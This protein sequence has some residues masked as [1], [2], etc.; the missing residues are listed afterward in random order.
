MVKP[1]NLVTQVV[2]S[3]PQRPP[4]PPREADNSELRSSFLGR[5]FFKQPGTQTPPTNSPCSSVESVTNITDKSQKKVEWSSSTE[6]KE[7]PTPSARHDTQSARNL[8]PLP[9]SG[10]RPAKSILKHYNGVNAVDKSQGIAKLSPPHTYLNFATMLESVVKQLAASDRN[11]RIDAYITLNGVLK[12]CGNIPDTHALKAKMGLLAQFIQRDMSAKTESGTTDTAVINHALTLLASLLWKPDVADS[13]DSDFCTALV[14]HAIAAF[15]ALSHSKEVVRLLLFI[16]GQQNFSTRIMT[17]ERAGLLVMALQNIE[18][19][20]KGRS[21]V[22]GRISVYRKLLKQAKQALL[23]NTDWVKHLFADLVSGIIDIRLAAV[24]FGI[25]AALSIGT[26]KQASRAVV[27]LFDMEYTGD[28]RYISYYAKRLS[29]MI[30]KKQDGIFVPQIWSV[31]VLFLRCRPHQLEQWVHLKPW[32]H[33]IQECFNYSDNDVKKQANFAWN[34]LVFTVRPDENTTP[35]MIKMLCQPLSGQLKRKTAGK[36]AREVR[37]ATLASLH[38]LLYYALRPNATPTQL[39]V[40]W[41][42]Y[43][44]QLVGNMMVLRSPADTQIVREDLTPACL[45]LQAL[46]DTCRPRPWVENRVNEDCSISA[47]DLPGLNPRWIR[48][49]AQRVFLVLSP[50]VEKCFWDLADVESPMFAVWK[51]F[52]SSVASAGAKEVI[53]SND[54]MTIMAYFFNLLYELWHKSSGPLKTRCEGGSALFLAAFTK[55]VTT[56]AAHLGVLPFTEK[57]LAISQ[58]DTFAVVATPSHRPARVLGDVKSPLHH[59]IVLIARP[60]SEFICDKDYGSMCNEILHPFFEARK[61]K[62]SRVELA[63]E[64][65]QLLVSAPSTRAGVAVWQVIARFATEATFNEDK[66]SSSGSGSHDR[67]LGVEYRNAVKILEVGL[68]LSPRTLLQEWR[69][70]LEA[71]SMQAGLEVGDGG[72]AISLIEPLSQ[73]LRSLSRRTHESTSFSY[74]LPLLDGATYPRERQSLDAARRRLWGTVSAN[75]KMSSSDP[76][77]HLYEYLSWCL[78]SSYES[79]NSDMLTQ[80]AEVLSA[81]A[82]LLQRCP[83]QHV[84][85]VLV[86]LEVGISHWVLDEA[87]KL[88]SRL[89]N[90]VFTSVFN[91]WTA[92]CSSITRLPQASSDVLHT[93]ETLLCS[94]LESKHRPIVNAT[95][96]FWNN[97]FGSQAELQYPQHVQTALRKLRHAADLQLPSFPENFEDEGLSSGPKFFDDSHQ[98]G[99]FSWSFANSPAGRNYTRFLDP[100]PFPKIPNSI[101][102]ER[103]KDSTPER[104]K[105]KAP[106]RSLTPKLRHDDSQIRFAAIESSPLGD[107]VFDSQLLTDRQREIRERQQEEAALFPDIQPI[108]RINRKTILPTLT[109]NSDLPREDPGTPDMLHDRNGFDNFITSSPTPHRALENVQIEVGTPDPPSSPPE[110]LLE[111]N[112]ISA[113][114]STGEREEDG[115]ALSRN[116][117]DGASFSRLSG[118]RLGKLLIA[119]P[120]APMQSVDVEEMT[121]Y[122]HIPAAPVEAHL[123]G[124]SSNSAVA[125]PSTPIETLGLMPDNQ[126]TPKTPADIFV[127]ALSSPAP[128]TPYQPVAG[129]AY[130]DGPMLPGG[131]SLHLWNK[132]MQR[133]KSSSQLSE[134]DEDSILR[135]MSKL[136]QPPSAQAAMQL[137]PFERKTTEAVGLLPDQVHE[138]NHA[139]SLDASGISTS[140]ANTPKE[141]VQKE[142]ASSNRAVQADVATERTAATYSSF[143]L[144]ESLDHSAPASP[145]PQAPINEPSI[146][147]SNKRRRSVGAPDVRNSSATKK[148]KIAQQSSAPH[149]PAAA[150]RRPGRPRKNLEPRLLEDAGSFEHD[151]GEVSVSNAEEYS[152]QNV[153]AD[154]AEV[155]VVDA[156]FSGAAVIS[157]LK[158]LLVG[159]KGAALARDEAQVVDTLIWDVKRE[160]CE[161]ER[162]GRG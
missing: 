3:L 108:P 105:R 63:R 98:N 32:L 127:D 101:S 147:A 142:S 114:G 133:P 89:M 13:F 144:S 46:F 56:M 5:L 76:Y 8:R 19:R 16:L 64:L 112:F 60:T 77:V 154:G 44:V 140:V 12:A 21:I 118:E 92:V 110:R 39:D 52:A 153:L 61:S 111:E 58:R 57:L 79:L 158:D 84:L 66:G 138:D 41:D 73:T 131:M 146:I 141:I 71:V 145:I 143:R 62:W 36:H 81:V 129:D 117:C 53:V 11:S 47:Q 95:A 78:Q 115:D 34:R 69:D 161:A 4:T 31:V 42:E 96:T 155:A 99:S 65:S 49:N 59:L 157:R 15:Q 67:P 6:Y 107:T 70:L 109:L 33:V 128:A 120:S 116:L 7:P 156:P 130:Q 28:I 100:S 14:D 24:G 106:K 22:L 29:S 20:F 160:V 83:S 119:E 1:G 93:I 134:M 159:L 97:T 50:L 17:M 9:P 35:S 75:Q 150:K 10:G 85:N 132:E 126:Q 45:I 30:R 113:P 38:N 2:G 121:D 40:Y 23:V 68:D 48:K 94:G 91:L 149:Q 104:L 122:Q 152:A 125:R 88:K 82:D 151:P 137:S 80:C 37:Q 54:T 27:E 51:T 139:G 43:V 25:E 72:R 103:P 90:T 162:R 123:Q 86:R 148:L 136:E 124:H 74:C 87:L 135:L 18:N 102:R 55:V 26:E